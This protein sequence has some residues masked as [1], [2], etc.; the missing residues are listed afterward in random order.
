MIGTSIPNK[1]AHDEAKKLDRAVREPQ[2]DFRLKTELRSGSG[3]PP[4]TEKQARGDHGSKAL[5]FLC[6]AM[7]AAL[8]L[9]SATYCSLEL[10]RLNLGLAG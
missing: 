4:L 5:Y 1:K 2:L 10:V 9:T 6:P 7:L 3:R 8:A